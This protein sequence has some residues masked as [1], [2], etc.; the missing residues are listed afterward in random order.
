MFFYPPLDVDVVKDVEG[1]GED[2]DVVKEGEAINLSTLVLK[3]RSLLEW[4]KVAAKEAEAAPVRGGGGGDG[5]GGGGEVELGG[6]VELTG[7][8][9]PPFH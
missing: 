3:R 5:S 2:E 4:P 1:M 6:V 9:S 8:Q 7:R